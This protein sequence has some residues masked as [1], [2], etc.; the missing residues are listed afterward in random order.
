MHRF[1]ARPAR[2]ADRGI[3]FVDESGCVAI[4]KTQSL[5]Q[6][7]AGGRGTRRGQF[8]VVGSEA[9]NQGGGG[10]RGAY[11]RGRMQANLPIV[12]R[13]KIVVMLAVAAQLGVNR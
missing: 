13:M 4:A 8:H 12:V 5:K 7:Q 3:W 9:R 11:E 6:R 10:L 1:E 2:G